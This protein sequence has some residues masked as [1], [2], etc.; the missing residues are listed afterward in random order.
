MSI[1]A[2]RTRVKPG[3][4]C[5]L[6]SLSPW[7]LF[8]FLGH[9]PRSA[10]RWAE[11]DPWL[12]DIY[13]DKQRTTAKPRIDALEQYIKT[14]LMSDDKTAAL[15][16]ISIIQFEPFDQEQIKNIEGTNACI[17]DDGAT[18]K[19]RILIDG[20]ARW[21]AIKGLL[22][23]FKKNNE[24][25]YDRLSK[26]DFSVALYTPTTTKFGPDVAGQLFTDFNAYAWPV[27]Q[28]KTIAEDMYN[29]YK[30][31]ADVV[32]QSDTIRRHGGLKVGTPNLGKKDTA[33]T[34]LL[35]MAQVCKI[36]VE[37]QRGMGRLA[38]PV[39]GQP[40]MATTS[41]EDAGA[42]IADFF[43]A[44]EL[45]MGVERFKDRSQIWRSAHG[46]YA[47]AVIMHDVFEGLTSLKDAAEGL[48]SI[49]WTWGNQQLCK[50]IGQMRKD[51]KGHQRWVLN[52]GGSTTLWLIQYC[53]KAC[54]VQLT[55]AA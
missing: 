28:A 7:R 36:A 16:P 9:D 14:R 54:G 39:S 15:P 19:N 49:D 42:R 22:D 29:P 11:L 1:V 51:G 40:K 24:A 21:T 10:G 25:A 38:K 50:Q 35:T 3:L 43:A 8:S 20:L 46:L 12:R 30:L 27:P 17:I 2:V 44:L 13:R 53:R 4:D 6:I 37:G 47:V 23:D 33:F 45:T 26:C 52:T 32:G 5:Y 31:T 55:Q 34:T 48:A 18:E 41:P